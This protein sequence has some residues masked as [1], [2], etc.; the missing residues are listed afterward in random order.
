MFTFSV[1]INC[2]SLVSLL[3]CLQTCKVIFCSLTIDE[4]VNNSYAKLMSWFGELAS[5]PLLE[6]S[7]EDELEEEADIE[8]TEESGE[9]E[10][11]HLSATTWKPFGAYFEN[12]L[13]HINVSSDT[14]LPTNPLYQPEFLKK[15]LKNWLPLSPFWSSMMRGIKYKQYQSIIILDFVHIGDP[16]RYKN[17]SQAIKEEVMHV[18]QYMQSWSKL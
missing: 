14:T 6:D 8:V 3:K 7:E 10:E 11:K 2:S 16:K 15:L 12:K 4:H 5:L 13:K 17:W 18:W 9:S 1:M